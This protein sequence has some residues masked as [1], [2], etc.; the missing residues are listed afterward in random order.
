MTGL[1]ARALTGLA[2]VNY[3][4][5]APCSVRTLAAVAQGLGDNILTRAAD[6]SLK[7]R[8]RLVLLVHES[9]P[10]LA[11][12]RAMTLVTEMGGIAMPPMPALYLRPHTVEELVEQTPARTLDP[13][14][15]EVPRMPHW[16]EDA[17]EIR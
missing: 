3:R 4:H 15:L 9:K 16:G 17:L 1:S 5:A 12:L 2:D 13:F 6:V 7:Q 11:H 8:R 10:T 14:D